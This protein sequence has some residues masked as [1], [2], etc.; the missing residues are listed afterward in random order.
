MHRPTAVGVCADHDIL[1]HLEEGAQQEQQE[2]DNL[3]D[4]SGVLHFETG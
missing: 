4:S 1:C 2:E 3:A